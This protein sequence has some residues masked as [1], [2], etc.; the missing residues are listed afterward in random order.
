[1]ANRVEQEMPPSK[2]QR[3][4]LAPNEV[5]ARDNLRTKCLTCITHWYLLTERRFVVEEGDLFLQEQVISAMNNCFKF[6][7]QALNNSGNAATRATYLDTEVSINNHTA[8]LEVFMTDLERCLACYELP[9]TKGAEWIGIVPPCLT[10]FSLH[11]YRMEELRMGHSR[12]PEGKNIQTDIS[13]FGLT[14]AHGVLLEGIRWPP[15]IRSSCAGSIGPLTQMICL[16]KSRSGNTGLNI[17]FTKKW[18]AALSDSLRHLPQCDEIIKLIPT[19]TEPEFGTLM[20][21]VGDVLLFTGGRQQQKV[22]LPIEAIIKRTE[23]LKNLMTTQCTAQG[24][25]TAIDPPELGISA[26]KQPLHT[27]I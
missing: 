13:R 21:A 9:A 16:R 17:D 4:G 15:S 25:I 3:T 26:R 19:C 11:K 12:V 7:R 8:K 27:I 24:P 14:S 1:M 22:A 20:R 2:R 10:L 23:T 5:Q 6:W 18:Q